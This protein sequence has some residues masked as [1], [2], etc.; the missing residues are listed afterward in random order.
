MQ[1]QI[2]FH[3]DSMFSYLIQ[4]KFGLMNSSELF[5]KML[6]KPILGFVASY[7]IPQIFPAFWAI[8]GGVSLLI[9]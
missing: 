9:R 2:K 8:S 1:A 4:Y 6:N 5:F 3:K 7:N